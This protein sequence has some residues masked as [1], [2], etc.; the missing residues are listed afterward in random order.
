MKKK[1]I[2]RVGREVIIEDLWK[3][4]ESS[5]LRFEVILSGLK[6][7]GNFVLEES[8]ILKW[9]DALGRGQEAIASILE[10]L[11]QVSPKP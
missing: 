9:Q 3:Q 4:I 2:Q 7:L 11:Q 6:N 10:K 1:T 5:S 8:E